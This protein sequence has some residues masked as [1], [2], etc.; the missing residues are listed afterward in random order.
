MERLKKGTIKEVI[1][2]TNPD[3]EGEATALYLTGALKPF[4]VR[5]SRI[6]YG[7]PVGSSLEYADQATL[8]KAM[9]GRRSLS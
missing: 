4:K 5:I 1:I 8:N 6:A 7:I 9:E 3:T 2:A